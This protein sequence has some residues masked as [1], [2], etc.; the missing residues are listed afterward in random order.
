MTENYP[1]VI[2]CYNRP[3]HLKR[4]IDALKQN[5]GALET[6][7]WFFSDG[8]ASDKDNDAVEAVRNILDNV[9]GFSNL[10]VEKS[11][12]NKGLATS[13]ITGVTRVLSESSACIVL[14]D[15]LETSPWFLDFMNEGLASYADDSEIFSVSGYCPPIPVPEDYWAEAFR[16]PR[17]NSWGWAT[18]RNRWEKVD[19]EVKDFDR[20]LKD[21]KV[22]KKLSLQGK[23]LPVMLLK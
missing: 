10:R 4:T 6:V 17:I 14:E 23:D 3:E 19:W 1:V 16:F 13:V 11:R 7:V 21:K 5:H 8:P 12:E 15:D 2:F 20:F 9:S 22:V 18:W